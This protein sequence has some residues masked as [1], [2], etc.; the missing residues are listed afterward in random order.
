MWGTDQSASSNP[1]DLKQLIEYTRM[2]ESTLG[3]R[4][5]VLEC[6]KNNLKKMR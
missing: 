4:T 1:A 2:L 3:M 5:D 6:E